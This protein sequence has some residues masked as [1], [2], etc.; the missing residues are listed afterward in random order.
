MPREKVGIGYR[1]L[2]V[3]TYH[4]WL[5]LISLILAVVVWFYVRD[6][7]SRFN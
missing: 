3:F 7:I 1:I 5:K 6:E 2:H 4:P